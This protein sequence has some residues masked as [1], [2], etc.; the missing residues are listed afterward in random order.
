[1]L[2]VEAAREAAVRTLEEHWDGTLPVDPI[3]IAKELGIEVGFTRFDD[4]LSGAIVADADK[5]QILI[6]EHESITRQ[7]F[8]CA[9]EIGH[10]M[11]RLEAKDKEYSF[12]EPSGN[13]FRNGRGGEWDLH[14]L[15]ADEFAANVLMPAE[16]FI[17]LANQ[18]VSVSDLATV[19]AVSR[20]AVQV[21][22]RKFKAEGVLESR[23]L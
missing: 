18:G 17:D 19:F 9:H 3:S 22:I 5:V 2:V 8:T 23:S 14:E 15:Y 20:A 21:R 13:A 12:Q 10:Y 11:E 7:V 4:E 1:M 16:R 6:A